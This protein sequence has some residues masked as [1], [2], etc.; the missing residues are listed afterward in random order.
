MQQQILTYK[1]LKDFL[2]NLSEKQLNQTIKI[3]V[4]DYGSHENNFSIGILD[5]DYINPSGEGAEPVSS[6]AFDSDYKDIFYEKEPRVALSGDI[7]L[8]LS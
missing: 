4:E 1:E 7:Y 6:Y 8:Y 2:E 5:E 3:W